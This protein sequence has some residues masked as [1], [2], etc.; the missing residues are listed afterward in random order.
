MSSPAVS[1][2][3]ACPACSHIHAVWSPR[4]LRCNVHGLTPTSAPLSPEP[5]PEPEPEP[6]D[7]PERA[8]ATEEE[9]RVPFRPRLVIARDRSPDPELT[10]PAEELADVLDTSD[11]PI[12]ITDVTEAS[13]VRTSTGL[14]PLDHVLGGGL[15][16]GSVV[17]LASPRG[18]GKSSLSL[19]MLAGL[20]HQCLYVS[21][22]ETVAQ[23]AAT[24]RRINAATSSLHVYVERNPA[25]IFAHA[26][27][28]RAK[29]IVI[30]SIQKMVCDEV[31]GR[32]GSPTQVKECTALFV[33]FA[34]TMETT[35]W[36]IGH[37]TGD[38][39]ISGPT[40]IEH[41]VDVVLELTA[42]LKLDGSERVIR[43]LGKNRF[44][45]SEL[46]GSFELTA[47]GLKPIDADGWNE[48]L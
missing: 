28:M 32:A 25:K 17:L 5:E 35:L 36:I 43:C 8:A 33:D 14:P 1:R 21:G 15:V 11:G 9:P 12:P 19:Q 23:V 42:G 3:F 41:D 7:R 45:P 48:P 26:R 16:V 44:G 29:T 47:T 34:K 20:G 13:F 46:T 30:D 40:T 18:I 2:R 27:K 31:N 39:T 37:V 6:A 22:E 10:D 4:C 38:G 24:A